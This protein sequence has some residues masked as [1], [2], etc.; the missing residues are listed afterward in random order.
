MKISVPPIR[1]ELVRILPV[2]MFKVRLFVVNKQVFDS[3]STWIHF[4]G[5]VIIMALGD[6]LLLSKAYRYRKFFSKMD[7][8]LRM[9][10][11]VNLGIVKY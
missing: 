5:M 4:P 1:G 8:C 6:L 9:G 7:N 10:C 2:K 3:Y 11:T